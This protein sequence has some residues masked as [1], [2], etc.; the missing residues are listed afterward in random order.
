M[1]QA[2]T[3]KSKARIDS[4]ENIKNSIV[5]TQ[6][7]DVSLSVRSTRLGGSI[8]EFKKIYKKYGEKVIL[9][10]F[11]Y[12][13]KK[14]EKIGII[15]ANGTGKTTFLNLIMGL[16]PLDMGFIQAG[17]TVVFGYYAQQGINLP[18]DMRVIETIRDIAEYI[19]M[20]DGS[21]LTP[22]QLL[23]R[24]NFSGE[25]Q[26]QLVSS[27]SGGE[28]RRL[29]LCTI[30]MTNPNFLIL[31]EP[32]NDLDILTL[33]VL[34]EFL[35]QFAGCALVVSHDRYFMDKMI[36]HL[37]VF[38]GKGKIKDFTGNYTQYRDAQIAEKQAQ[39]ALK[40]NNNNQAT[41]PPAANNIPSKKAPPTKL[42]YKEQQELQTLETQIATLETQKTQLLQIL[43][44]PDHNHEQL[45][46]LS[47]QFEKL[48]QDIDEKSLRW[49][50]LTDKAG[51]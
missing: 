37:F 36:D 45:Q 26:Y 22:T 32:T 6:N 27:L 3:T 46:V 34:D 51:I 9:E 1:P 24:F 21:K 42:N 10:N 15:G 14:G 30:L 5:R 48:T 7:N 19:P 16:E 41:P 39:N 47:Q 50:E 13:F 23:H 35:Q 11:S 31:D 38:E 49:L 28:K 4:F 25:Q 20:A 29:Y 33:S 17:Q 18:A 12:I 8:L 40:K 44:Q 2:R 43:N